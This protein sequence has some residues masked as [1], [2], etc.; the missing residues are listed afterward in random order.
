MQ[1]RGENE[2]AAFG[3]ESADTGRINPTPR[4][5]TQGQ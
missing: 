5:D 3:P 4:R 2:P 1:R